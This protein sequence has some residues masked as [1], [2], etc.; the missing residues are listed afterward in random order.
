ME[1]ISA[2]ASTILTQKY[3]H[4]VPSGGAE[5]WGDVASRVAGSVMGPLLPAEARPARSLIAG[6]Q[7]M[8][9]GRYLYAAGRRYPQCQ[10]CALFFAEDSR[11]GWADVLRK[12]AAT[13]MTGAGIGV[14]YSRLRQRGSHIGGMGGKSSGPVALMNMVNEVG[15][16]VRQGGD[17]RSAI[18]A[19]L[20]WNHPDCREFIACKDWPDWLRERR[21][22]DF[23]VPCPMDMTNISVI[24]DDDFFSAY[25]DPCHRDH[26]LARSIY[27]LAVESMCRGGEPGFS[28]DVGD[29]AG[30]HGRNACTEVV[31]R[32]DSD[33]CN[34]GSLNLARFDSLADFRPAVRLAT[35]FLLC[36]TVY[37]TLPVPEMEAVR[38]ADRRIGL[39][40]MGLHEWLLKRGKRYGPDDELAEWLTAY[41]DESAAAAREYAGKLSVARPIA[42]RSI[43]PTGTI[44]IVAET[45]SGIE[46]VFATAF[47]RRYLKGDSWHAQYVVD[48][49]AKRLVD[50]GV[51]PDG[52][53][54]AYDLAGDVRRRVSFQAWVQRYVDQAISSTINLPAWGSPQNNPDTVRPFGETLLAYLPHLRGVT[55]YPDGSRGGQ[56][57]TKIPY[58][59]A[60]GRVGVEFEEHG[61]EH[62]CAGGVCGS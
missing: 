54:D 52:I 33:V 18:W 40:L 41:R 53:E 19:G 59:E 12:A 5:S 9:G 51:D 58:R 34:L 24:L 6:R 16:G 50:S 4:P 3:A 15:R 45:T 43:A 13:L 28:V 47:L 32:K 1:T 21:S 49:C 46:P 20:H 30:E 22:V 61:N 38:S 31:T 7:F 17:R 14:V 27:W 2:F 60:A 35:A 48:A 26:G 10:N 44:S 11:D 36:G 39:G 37:S 62:S 57:L 8:P 56:P 55:A 25:A 23:N 29:N 42:V